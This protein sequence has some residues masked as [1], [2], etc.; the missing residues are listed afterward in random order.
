MKKP[1][2]QKPV[3]LPDHIKHPSGKMKTVCVTACLTAIGVPFES[4][5]VTGTL[6]NPNYLSLINKVGYCAR[7]RKSK[8]PKGLTIGACRK[9]IKNLGEN[10][11]YFVVVNGNGYCHAML[12]DNNGE[13]IV[14]TAP[15]K[16]DKRKVHSI[17]AV[18]IG[19]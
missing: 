13:T 19:Q 6:Q 18:F 4:F 3:I 8:M 11:V 15:R 12:I 7:S 1:T 14:D 10:A 2:I 5:Q 9:A 17:H 16:K